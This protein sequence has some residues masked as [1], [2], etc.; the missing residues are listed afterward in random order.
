[1]DRASLQPSP[2]RSHPCA[3]T[4]QWHALRNPRTR[5]SHPAANAHQDLTQPP[6][7]IQPLSGAD[8]RDA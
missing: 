7:F 4:P 3:Q 6:I 2:G 1:M 5:T 8:D